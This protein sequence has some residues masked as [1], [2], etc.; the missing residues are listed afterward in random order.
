MKRSFLTLAVAG[1]VGIG[2][3][4]GAQYIETFESLD[5]AAGNGSS[6]ESQLVG[7]PSIGA[8]WIFGSRFGGGGGFPDGVVVDDAGTAFP[9]VGSSKYLQWD[10]TTD[11]Y[12][13]ATATSADITIPGSPAPLANTGAGD[14]NWVALALRVDSLATD[15]DD[16]NIDILFVSSNAGANFGL[17]VVDG[18]FRMSS[19]N[20]FGEVSISTSAFD[21]TD[22]A[23]NWEGRG[24]QI[25]AGRVFSDGSNAEAKWWI[26]DP[27]DFSAEVLVDETG[28][29]NA[30]SQVPFEPEDVSRVGF[31][32]SLGE[33]AG[34][35]DI[36]VSMD[37]VVFFD[38]TV[39]TNE[40]EFVAAIEDA[41]GDPQTN[42]ADWMM[43]E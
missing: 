30:T 4:A 24:W 7:T 42:V 37:H 29:V 18:L 17:A 41:F 5:D 26:I 34:T 38:G 32:A 22:A 13:F 21:G 2:S 40:S 14:T 6:T 12:I 10:G 43:F 20:R 31:F 1:L 8:D 16:N 25:L 33:P 23:N 36:Q 15:N 9:G 27:S 3:M 35:A 39:V 28:V 19:S 11:Q